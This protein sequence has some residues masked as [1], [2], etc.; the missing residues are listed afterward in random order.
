M[1]ATTMAIQAH[2]GNYLFNFIGSGVSGTVDITFAIDPNTGV[3][4]GTSPNPVDPIGAYIVTDV[5]GTFS[6]ANIGISNASITGAVASNPANP[7]PTNLL[8]PHSFGWYPVA[9]GV[10]GPGGVAP[11]FS[12]D[13]LFYPAGSPQTASDYPF[14]GGVFDIYGIVFTIA[15]GDAVNLWSNGDL[16]AGVNY[17]VGVTDGTN[18]LDYVSPIAGSVPEPAGWALMMLGVA[19]V[20]GAARIAGRRSTVVQAA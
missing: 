17:G 16:G 14:H 6:D 9:N 8:A 11:G 13:E 19:A 5:T 7:E 10:P 18:V 2:A 20:G 1:A 4:P 3:L 12:Y 15:G